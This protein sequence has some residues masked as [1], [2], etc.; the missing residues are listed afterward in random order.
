[1]QRHFLR[2]VGWVMALAVVST[3]FALSDARQAKAEDLSTYL[4]KPQWQRR[5]ESMQR[6]QDLLQGIEPGSTAAALQAAPTPLATGPAPL[7]PGAYPEFG[8]N[9]LV[10]Y[11]LPNFAY[12]PNLRKF[13]NGLP[14]LG[15]A[16]QNNIGQ[17]IPVAAA[18]N[19]TFPGN[20]YY[21][22]GVKQYQERMHSDLPAAGTKLR[23]YYQINGTDNSL[24]YLGPLIIAH[25]N[26]AVR[27][28]YFN[29]LGLGT[30]GNLPIPVDNTV[31]GAGE[32]PSG[33]QYTQN[34]ISIHLHGGYTPWISDGTPHQWITP[35]SG[36]RLPT[37]RAPVSRTCP[38]WSTDR[39]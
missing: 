39:S 13:V 11:A 34:R 4:S 20:D 15:S 10:D 30:A 19:T 3:G 7:A 31:M 35:A 8:F 37:R 23:G 9:P 6:M 33:G 25:R 18:D 22:I 24:Q 29:E 16:N 36:I 21:E 32:G 17:Y 38:T 28:K 12:S 27:I 14:G 5:Q 26:R 2:F 1:M